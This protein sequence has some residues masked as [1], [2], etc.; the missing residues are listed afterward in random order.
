MQRKSILMPK[1]KASVNREDSV[2]A[3]GNIAG[4]LKEQREGLEEL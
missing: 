1:K 4:L 3:G 2:L